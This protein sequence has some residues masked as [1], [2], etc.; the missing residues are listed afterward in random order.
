M[1]AI[2]IRTSKQ[3]FGPLKRAE[4]CRFV[5]NGLIS[6]EDL[7]W[8]YQSNTW[9]KLE[10][11]QVFNKL[12]SSHRYVNKA[13]KI[14]AIA[15][16]KGGVG[17]TAL[18]A[19]LAI[20]LANINHKVIIVDADFGGPDLHEWMGISRP[21]VTLNAYFQNS[22]VDLSQLLVDTNHKNIKMICGQVGSLESS[23]PKF[24][25]RLKFI[26]QLRELP[27]D[28]VL[29]DQSPGVS[30]GTVDIFLACDDGIIVTLPEA[31]SFMDAF[32]FIRSA[33]L[34]KLKKSLAFSEYALS[35]LEEFE[36]W[37][38]RK[39]EQ[40]MKQIL[41]RVD[42]HDPRAGTIFK[43]VV[44]KFRPNLI[45]NMV[46]DSA[47]PKEAKYFQEKISN[48]LMVETKFLGFIDY[49][50]NFRKTVKQARPFILTQPE[51]DEIAAKPKIQSFAQRNKWSPFNWSK[52]QPENNVSQNFSSK[53]NNGNGVT[54]Y[55][56]KAKKLALNIPIDV[57]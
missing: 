15:S 24:F 17:K 33:L 8:D 13:G 4:F 20:E 27:C 5:R 36:N 41:V 37:D 54:S 38:W 21:P 19:S 44:Q 40:P 29:I 48:L 2:Y 49:N 45:M 26:R 56:E 34:R 10:K 55:E 30:Y 16:G 42:R 23:N 31:T 35:Q 7:F 6:A 39:Y 28:Y 9:E 50:K 53:E 18:T 51:A 47:E 22:H 52:K 3:Q 11:N 57:S 25:K 12:V 14:I 46:L 1:N 32:H 43:G